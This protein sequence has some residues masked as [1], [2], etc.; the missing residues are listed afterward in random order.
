MHVAGFRLGLGGWRY[1]PGHGRILLVG[2]AAG[3]VDPLLGEG[4]YHA[5]IS[6]Q[7]AASAVSEALETGG[8]ACRSYARRLLP[9][10][11]DL[12]F[13]RLASAVF[14]SLPAAGHLLLASPAAGSP[15]MD[16]FACGM[17]LP[18][19]FFNPHRFIKKIWLRN[20]IL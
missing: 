10:R 17:P 19:I 20:K 12:L 6:G 3:L 4:V 8:D 11:R 18:D 2:D 9:V 1:R 13:S 14:Y 5:V 16:G 7:Q 15:L